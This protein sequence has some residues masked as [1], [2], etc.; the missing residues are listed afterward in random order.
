MTIVQLVKR[1]LPERAIR[2]LRWSRNTLAFYCDRLLSVDK[3]AFARALGDLGVRSGDILVVLSSLDQMR[4]I[5]ATPMELIDL[6]GRSV[7]AAGTVVMPSF[8]MSGLS[9]EHLDLHPFFDWRRTPSRSGMLTEIFRRTAG[10]ERSLHPTHPVAARG[11]T[12]A[13]LTE[14]HER[15][16]TPFDEHSPFQKLLSRNA[17]VLT[18]G[19]FDAMPF[20]HLADHLLQE[21]IPYPIY[22][23]RVVTVRLRAKDGSERTMTTRAHNPD[24]VCEHRIVLEAMS[25]EG[26]LARRRVRGLRLSL[27]CAQAYVD[28]YQRYHSR[29][30]LQY[31]LK[32]ERGRVDHPRLAE[33]HR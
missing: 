20:R 21:R 30:S 11:A 10:T 14:G 17:K 33:S 8:P 32:S 4:S 5:R 19:S 12:A 26:L 15:S 31:Y 13:W 27:C 2:K 7:G 16:A 29:G 25:R 22:G 18:L 6:L 9:Q 3:V 24:L 28:A 23:D 1:I